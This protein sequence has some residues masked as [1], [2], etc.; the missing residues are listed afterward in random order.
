LSVAKE[1]Y[2][3]PPFHDMLSCCAWSC[4]SHNRGT[5]YV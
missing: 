2:I 4:A 5:N 1:K 3:C